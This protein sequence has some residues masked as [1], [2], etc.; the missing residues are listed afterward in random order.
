MFRR[1]KTCVLFTLVGVLTSS[2][3]L[4]NPQQRNV[5]FQPGNSSRIQPAVMRPA[6]ATVSFPRWSGVRVRKI[7][8]GLLAAVPTALNGVTFAK[9][10]EAVRA[11][12]AVSKAGGGQ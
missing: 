9:T 12:V 10:S 3:A 7:T 6:D 1:A 5:V 11:P 2:A 4:L 8:P